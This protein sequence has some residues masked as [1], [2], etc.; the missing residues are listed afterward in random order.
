[1]DKPKELA[2][3]NDNRRA[4][5]RRIARATS[6]LEM[7]IKLGYTSSSYLVQM[8]GPAPRRDVSEKTARRIETLYGLPKLTI[9]APPASVA[10]E[11]DAAVFGWE[12]PGVRAAV[13]AALLRR[14]LRTEAPQAGSSAMDAAVTIAGA[15]PD[16]TDEIVEAF[17]VLLNSD[18]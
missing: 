6:P 5:V 9:D 15:V 14:V 4:N 3:T 10:A 16:M 12:Q 11:I 7:S 8:I 13:P 18:S 2:P 17:G 1:M